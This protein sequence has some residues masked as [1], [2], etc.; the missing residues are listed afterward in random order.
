MEQSSLESQSRGCAKTPILT[1]LPAYATKN[2]TALA[3][4]RSLS[5][6]FS[7]RS[8]INSG[9]RAA[10]VVLGI[11]RKQ[12]MPLFCFVFPLYTERGEG[13]AGGGRAEVPDFSFFYLFS[14]LNRPRAGLATV[15]S[16]FYGLASSTLNVRDNNAMKRFCFCRL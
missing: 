6:T 8:L 14:L 4:P 1:V 3:R 9:G 13:R 11:N 10:R 7:K 2:V 16:R 15:R 12:V 5:V